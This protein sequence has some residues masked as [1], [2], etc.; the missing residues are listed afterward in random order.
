[1]EVA[2]EYVTS[3]SAA[4]SLYC[5]NN[6]FAGV[7][8]FLTQVNST[9]QESIIIKSCNS[10]EIIES[11][12]PDTEY[13]ISILYLSD[14]LCHIGLTITD[15]GKAKIGKRKTSVANDSFTSCRWV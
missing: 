13:I 2:V 15:P 12:L 14:I 3:E 5:S 7:S 9:L 10:T 8:L 1:M 11:L 6:D 4:I